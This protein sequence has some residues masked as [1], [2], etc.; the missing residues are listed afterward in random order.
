MAQSN[1]QSLSKGSV[2]K[3]KMGHDAG[4][5]YVVIKVESGFVFLV[6]G[7]RRKLEKPKRK[8]ASH[9]TK[10]N[11]VV[12]NEDLLTNKKIRRVLWEL[13]FGFDSPVA[14]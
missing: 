4:S 1:L 8:N 2:V 5:F 14:C 11:H 13:N 9:V 7:R 12:G 3:S 6:D 10:T